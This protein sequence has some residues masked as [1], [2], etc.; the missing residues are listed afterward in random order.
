MREGE[1]AG[2]LRNPVPLVEL[3]DAVRRFGGT[4]AV[5]HVSLSIREGEFFALLGPSGCGKTTLMRLIAGFETPDAGDVLLDGKS[6]AGVP[7]H[8]RPVNMMFQSYALFPHLTVAENIGFGLREQGVPKAFRAARIDEALA[9][10]RLEGLGER[11]PDRLSGGQ[12]QRVALARA[13]VLRPR[14]LL[15]DEPLAALDRKLREETQRELKRIQVEL[16]TAFLV[17]T[18]DQDEAMSLADRVAVMAQGRIRQ[19]GPPA[20]VYENPVDR[21][22]AGFVGDANFLACTVLGREG[23]AWRLAHAA[24]GTTLLDRDLRDCRPGERVDLMVRP[25]KLALAAPDAASGGGNRLKGRLVD[26]VYRGDHSVCR[27]EIAPDLTL[28]AIRDHRTRA[29]RAQPAPGDAVSLRFGTDDAVML[30]AESA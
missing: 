27:V 12:R 6:L 14:L 1:A 7:P 23:D 22:V 9:L 5:D 11:R 4:P 15:L 2:V 19:V 21:F 17:V 29:D 8:R 30:P 28:T 13:L 25:E 20:E 3:R 18:H 10:V 24:T 16:G 26:V